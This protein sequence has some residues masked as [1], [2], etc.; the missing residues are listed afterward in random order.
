MYRSRT[1]PAK[2]FE[3]AMVNISHEHQIWRKQ[4]LAEGS[5]KREKEDPAIRPCK[6]GPRSRR[7]RYHESPGPFQSCQLAHTNFFITATGRTASKCFAPFLSKTPVCVKPSYTCNSFIE[8]DG[9]EQFKHEIWYNKC[10]VFTDFQ[11]AM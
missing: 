3:K 6:C 1:Q 9:T 2:Y 4:A 11:L 10:F 5:K 7:S 8:I